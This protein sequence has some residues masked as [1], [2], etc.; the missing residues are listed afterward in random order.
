MTI[1]AVLSRFAGVEYELGRADCWALV[2]TYYRSLLGI[3]LDERESVRDIAS[4]VAARSSRWWAVED[5]RDGDV[6]TFRVG[7]LR[8]GHC[9]VYHGGRVLHFREGSGLLNQPHRMVRPFLSGVFR[10]ARD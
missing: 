2:E 8:H 4:G 6:L 7:P 3:T 9:G 10:Y 5:L 1:D